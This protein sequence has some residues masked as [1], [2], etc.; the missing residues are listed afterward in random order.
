MFSNWMDVKKKSSS[1]HIKKID[2]NKLKHM[3]QIGSVISTHKKRSNK[4]YSR[5]KKT[6]EMNHN[7]IT[8]SMSKTAHMVDYAIQKK[9]NANMNM[10]YK[11]IPILLD[12]DKIICL[13]LFTLRGGFFSEE[14][15]IDTI[16]TLSSTCRFMYKYIV[17][18]MMLIIIDTP[19]KLKF[20]NILLRCNINT[21]T[22]SFNKFKM[23]I[24]G[25]SN[26]CF[27]NFVEIDGLN[28]INFFSLA[29]KLMAVCK[30]IKIVYEN[31]RDECVIDPQLF[32][33]SLKSILDL[34]KSTVK[35]INN[36]IL[37]KRN[38]YKSEVKILKSILK[39]LHL[40]PNVSSLKPIK[41]IYIRNYMTDLSATLI[42]LNSIDIITLESMTLP[43]FN[44]LT[45]MNALHG[46]KRLTLVNV[47]KIS[48]M[49]YISHKNIKLTF[50]KSLVLCKC[51]TLINSSLVCLLNSLPA[52]TTLE[53][54]RCM[55]IDSSIFNPIYYTI[56]QGNGIKHLI[57]KNVIHFFSVDTIFIPVTTSDL[58]MEGIVFINNKFIKYMSYNTTM[59]EICLDKI[60]FVN[61]PHA[62]YYTKKYPIVS[63]SLKMIGSNCNLPLTF[64]KKIQSITVCQSMFN[65][66]ILE[67]SDL[68]DPVKI[69]SEIM[70]K[71]SKLNV[72]IKRNSKSLLLGKYITDLRKE[73]NMMQMGYNFPN[74]KEL[75]LII[76]PTIKRENCILDI[77]NISRICNFRSISFNKFFIKQ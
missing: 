46:C 36:T 2:I 62:C 60:S 59:G 44:K 74:L 17:K 8:E 43:R 3:S 69:A 31:K 12:Q 13:T 19:D 65:T 42:L 66:S 72:S 73:I 53:I 26:S 21:K 14:E 49:G 47:N 22:T 30:I 57:I 38:G 25:K 35:D 32:I 15:L 45:L 29:K 40:K 70:I 58:F 16:R 24:Y 76:N 55:G 10:L 23:S 28:G 39:K 27:F 4:Y 11:K 18:I 37:N 77:S 20:T 7:D 9:T 34:R 50:L 67:F 61:C 41:S 68:E 51:K 1:Q 54:D 64:F 5:I 48:Q 75:N 56:S 71:K 33:K 52:I 63:R 6:F